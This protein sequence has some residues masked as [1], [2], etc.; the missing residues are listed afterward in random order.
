MLS[1]GS[2]SKCTI[3]AFIFPAFNLRRLRSSPWLP[4][5]IRAPVVVNGWIATLLAALKI[6]ML[7][8]V[9]IAAATLGHGET[10]HF[11]QSGAT[12]TCTGVE[13][14]LRGGS[15]GFAAALIGALFAY[16]GWNALNWVAGEVKDPGRTLPLAVIRSVAL[17]CVLYVIANAAYVFVLGPQA[18][19]SLRPDTSVGIVAVEAVFGRTWRSIAAGFSCVSVAATLHVTILSAA[20]VTYAFSLGALGFA[21]LGRL[22]SRGRVPVNAV[23]ANSALA[24]VLVLVGT[25]DTLSNY[26]IFNAC[27]TSRGRH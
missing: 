12:G 10:A 3:T 26:F 2:R 23:L 19:A 8:G 22:S 14:S 16:N 27:R 24:C 7:A 18:I 25:F 11:V 4:Q 17:V 15:A 1:T 21:P 9:A 20:R 5:L 6:A 13:A